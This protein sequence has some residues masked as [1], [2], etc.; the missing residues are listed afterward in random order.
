MTG[1]VEPGRKSRFPFRWLHR[2]EPDGLRPFCDRSG[3]DMVADLGVG[4][5]L[6]SRWFLGL[7]R[8]RPWRDSDIVVYPELVVFGSHWAAAASGFGGRTQHPKYRHISAW[9][10]EQGAR[11]LSGRAVQRVTID[12]SAYQHLDQ[13]IDGEG[14]LREILKGR[15]KV[16]G[17]AAMWV[18]L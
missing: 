12:A 13:E 15:Q 16:W 18:G 6:G 8:F 9:W 5:A 11:G 7:L 1:A 3:E 17:D 2:H 10:P 14:T 4:L